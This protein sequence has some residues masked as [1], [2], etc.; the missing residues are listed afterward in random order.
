MKGLTHKQSK[1]LRERI[2]AYRLEGHYADEAAEHFG[3][4]LS[5]VYMA[6][7]GHECVRREAKPSV[8][9]NQYTVAS[10]DREANAKR[11]IE[12]RTDGFEYAGGFTG[13]DGFVN[14]RCVV[15]GDIRLPPLQ[16]CPAT[17]PRDRHI[18]LSE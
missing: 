1:E 5:Y 14:L 3:V 13:I 17:A 11:Y 6:S 4:P 7:K 10:F 16:A 8:Y 2:V 18:R 15:C 12:E 9:R